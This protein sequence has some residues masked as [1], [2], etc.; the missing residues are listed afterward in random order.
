MS[1]SS[2]TGNTSNVVTTI[3][4]IVPSS[5]PAAAQGNA[6]EEAGGFMGLPPEI[7]NIIYRL[8]LCSQR[9]GTIHFKKGWYWAHVLSHP[10][11]HC[12][13]IIPSGLSPALLSTNSTIHRE[14]TPILY[15]EN[16]FEIN[17]ADV[18]QVF[19]RIDHSLHLLRNASFF[20]AYPVLS[21]KMRDTSFLRLKQ[22]GAL[23]SLTL[24]QDP[25]RTSPMLAAKLLL[26]CIKAVQ[27]RIDESAEKDEGQSAVEI[28]HFGPH[29]VLRK[30]RPY[31]DPG[32]ESN[33]ALLEKYGEQVKAHLQKALDKE[34]K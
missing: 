23:R 13:L 1:F 3:T 4:T 29:I 7:R 24:C 34:R 19:D 10:D 9:R 16:T 22:L 27:K 11:R 33:M 17:L 25:K 30:K 2:K 5:S 12:G 21:T 31:D 18:G 8:V 14:A 32:S 28:L 20:R 26:P 15:G 6:D